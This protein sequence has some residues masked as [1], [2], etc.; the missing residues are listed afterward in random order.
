MLTPAYTSASSHS[1]HSMVG[2]GGGQGGHGGHASDMDT[3]NYSHQRHGQQLQT[4]GRQSKF[5]P[6]VTTAT[7]GRGSGFGSNF[8]GQQ[9]QAGPTPGFGQNATANATF[10]TGAAKTRGQAQQPERSFAGGSSSHSFPS[11]AGRAAG[12]GAMSKYEPPLSAAASASL[13]RATTQGS[14][15]SLGHPQ[16]GGNGNFNSSDRPLNTR[17]SSGIRGSSRDSREVTR[18]SGRPVVN[19]GDLLVGVGGRRRA[20]SRGGIGRSGGRSASG[21]VGRSSPSRSR[22]RSPVVSTGRR[23]RRSRSRHVESVHLSSFVHY[24][25]RAAILCFSCQPDNCSPS[26]PSFI[27]CRSLLSSPSCLSLHNLYYCWNPLPLI[28]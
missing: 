3:H 2:L 16:R 24:L 28:C 6:A 19:A 22:S 14:R 5:S 8:G 1:S 9:Q 25:Y 20:T 17:D 15:A 13:S 23:G 27:P 10:A 12:A 26:R 11:S 4:G 7:V 21:G 18:D